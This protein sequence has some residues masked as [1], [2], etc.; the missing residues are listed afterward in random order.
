MQALEDMLLGLGVKWMVVPA[1]LRILKTVWEGK[2]GFA[3]LR[4]GGR[5]G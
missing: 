2:L 3:R 5:P 4:W 1:A